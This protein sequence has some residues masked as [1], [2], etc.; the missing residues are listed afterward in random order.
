MRSAAGVP[1]VHS[2]PGGHASPGAVARPSEREALASAL[3][4]RYGSV[5]QGELRPRGAWLEDADMILDF[6]GRY[7][8]G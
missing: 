8:R 3:F 5:R 6:M 4:A 7:P 2:M 1:E